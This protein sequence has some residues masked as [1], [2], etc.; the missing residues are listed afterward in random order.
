VEVLHFSEVYVSL[1]REGRLK[2][3]TRVDKTV[4]FHDPCHVGRSQGLFNEPREILDAIPGIRLVEMAHCREESR[5]CGAGGGVK[6]NYPEMAAQIARDRVIEAMETG[7]DTLVTMCPFC[8]A[9]FSQAIGELNGT[10][11]LMGLE[12][13]LL[14]SLQP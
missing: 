13:L 10:I 9:S 5:C 4:T 11:K 1:I 14:E 8:Q 12:Q 3:R 2:P 7:A 6:A